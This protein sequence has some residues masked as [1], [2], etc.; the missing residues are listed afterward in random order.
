[1]PNQIHINNSPT[2]QSFVSTI[3]STGEALGIMRNL[4]ESSGLSNLQVYHE[5]L[6]SG[7]RSSSPHYHTKRE[8]LV[9]VLSGEPSVWLNGNI[10]Q[11]SPKDFVAFKAGEDVFHMIL[12]ETEQVAELLVISDNVEGD[13]VIYFQGG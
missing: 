10:R 7:R 11:L 8:E 3:R 1:M 9:Y 4:S 13:E 6:L 12:N 5:T 2:V